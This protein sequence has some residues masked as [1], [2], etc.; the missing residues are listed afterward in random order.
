VYAASNLNL[1]NSTQK[2][3]TNRPQ[4]TYANRPTNPQRCVRKVATT[5]GDPQLESLLSAL[6]GLPSEAP[7]SAQLRYTA[8]LVV[9]SYADWLGRSLA[10]GRCQGLLQRWVGRVLVCCGKCCGFV[11]GASWMWFEYGFQA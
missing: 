2:P 9:A 4:L 8:A 5:P 11:L 1:P 3:K 7:G 10:M 6:P